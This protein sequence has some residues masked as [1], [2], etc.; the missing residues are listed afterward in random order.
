ML[1]LS[2]LNAIKSQ[3]VY[4]VLFCLMLIGIAALYSAPVSADGGGP[5]KDQRSVTKTFSCPSGYTGSITS[6]CS[7]SMCGFN[8]YCA[9]SQGPSGGNWRVK[10]NTCVLAV[11]FSYNSYETKTSA[12]PTTQPSGV[13]NLRRDFEVW[14]DGSKRNY[15]AWY[16][17]S[18]SCTAVMSSTQTETRALT[19]PSTKPSGTW[20]Q[21][22]TY[23]LWTDGSKKNYSAWTDV[24]NTCSAIKQSTQTE[25]RSLAC[26]AA[27]PTGT[28][29]QKRT[30]EI[31]S[32]GTTK[33][34]GAWTDVTVCQNAAPAAQ[35]KA[36]TVAEDASGS[37]T[38]TAIDDHADLAFEIVQQ[39]ANGNASI[40]GSTLTFSPV[41]NWN[42]ATSLTYRA[43]DPYGS[44]SAPVQVAII[45]ES[46]NDAPVART[47]ALTVQED[48][49][50]QLRLQSSDVDSAGPFLF[51]IVKEPENLDFSLSGDEL[52][53]MANH[54]WYGL[55]NLTYRVRDEL[56]LWSSPA[57]VNIEVTPS[58]LSQVERGEARMQLQWN[59]KGFIK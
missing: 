59:V 24:T 23:D 26:P 43:K 44:Y 14:S 53:V 17:T 3:G 1:T 9:D 52:T 32:D 21:K 12:C 2:P 4:A 38:L 47:L 39:P 8:N 51:E 28:W 54:D 31:W 11:K 35:A 30:Y 50:A 13:I 29:T 55:T 18:R 20:T 7:A 48:K 57:A 46:V 15:S 45:V 22:R 36:L 37:V 58:P 6:T 33:N 41:A 19:C 25:T 16:E 34:Y 40:S 5:C 27:T 42:G 56:G 10:S 49:S